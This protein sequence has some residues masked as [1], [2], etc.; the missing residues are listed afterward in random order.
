MTFAQAGMTPWFAVALGGAGG[1]CLRFAVSLWV[2]VPAMP[3]WPWATFLVNL[4][5]G[6]L[7]GLLAVLLAAS[8]VN[9]VWRLALT[10]GL[11]G[12]LTTFST[13]SFELVRMIEARAWLLAGGYALASVLACASLAGLGLALGRMVFE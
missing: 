1:A 4:V 8:H 13:F 12:A 10:T 6:F 5:G 2:G 11:L 9:E 7:F 3:A